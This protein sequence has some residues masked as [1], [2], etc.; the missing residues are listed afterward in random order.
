LTNLLEVLKDWTQAMDEGKGVDVVFLDYQKTFDTV[1]HKRLMSKL[2]GYGIKG[3]VLRWIEKFLIG[4][5]MR[6]TLNGTVSD[7]IL[8]LSGVP[9][10]SVLGPLLFLI[11]VNDIP[12]MVNSSIKLF[13]DDTKIW[14]VIR[15]IRDVMVLQE[16]LVKLDEWADNWLLKFN[17]E[18]C[19][20]MHIGKNEKAEY[21]LRDEGGQKEISKSSCE[22]DLGV[23][24][25]DDLKWSEQCSKA[26]SKAMSVLGIIKRTFKTVDVNGFKILYNTYV[27]PH[28][29]YCAQVWSPYYKKDLEILEKVQRRATKMVYGLSGLSYEERMRKLD[30]SSLEQRR[31]RGDLIEAYKIIQGKE[32]VQSDKFFTMARTNNLRG[33]GAKLYKRQVR[34]DIRKHFFSSR[35]VDEWNRLPDNVVSAENTKKFKER[36][37][38]WM[39]RHMQ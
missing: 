38:Q 15:S 13:A 9:Q 31:I 14:K 37:D 25:R 32:G 1:P 11:Y 8:V 27:R 35:I 2:R 7:W 17:V 16:D 33:N 4:R 6:V 10:G 28:M 36:L 18:K 19:K 39:L 30:L 3:N 12:S 23:W 24:I 22:K 29:E 5:K 34:L 21:S 20:V 26:A